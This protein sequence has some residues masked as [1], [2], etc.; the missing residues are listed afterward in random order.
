MVRERNSVGSSPAA[1]LPAGPANGSKHQAASHSAREQ[2]RATARIDLP[3]V[4]GCPRHPLDAT[5]CPWSPLCTI[6]HAMPAF[7]LP[8][9]EAGE[10]S[11]NESTSATVHHDGCAGVQHASGAQLAR[12]THQQRR[13]VL[14]WC[15]EHPQ[16]PAP[17]P[18]PAASAP[19]W[20]LVCC[21]MKFGS[22]FLTRASFKLSHILYDY[23]K[24]GERPP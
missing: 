21:R 5:C 10:N 9:M 18:A 20:Q 24:L 22:I 11:A 4:D 17:A 23:F 8:P 15:W 12:T 6:W 14:G 3:S 13:M 16:P 7:F 19:R 1:R 2:G